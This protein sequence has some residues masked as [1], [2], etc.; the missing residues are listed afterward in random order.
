[1][2]E[3]KWCISCVS[4]KLSEEEVDNLAKKRLQDISQ[5]KEDTVEFWQYIQFVIVCILTEKDP[6]DFTVEVKTPMGQ[7]TTHT[8]PLIE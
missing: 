6:W 1:M 8:N 4:P 7:R 5:G 3:I 2:D